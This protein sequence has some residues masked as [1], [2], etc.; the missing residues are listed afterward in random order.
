MALANRLTPLQQRR[1]ARVL[2]AVEGQ[3]EGNLTLTGLAS[4]AGCSRWQLQRAFAELDITLAYYVRQR[5]LCRA[6]W[7]LVYS[8]ERQ[9][10]IA[11]QCG[12]ESDIQFHRAFK[13]AFHTTPGRYRQRGSWQDCLLPLHLTDTALHWL[14]GN[15]GTM[16]STEL[17][18]GK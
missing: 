5:R 18:V 4:V 12:F 16:L 13:Q 2:E 14:D 15:T 9:A 17:V 3:L 6:A 1:V 10:D 11:R 8:C 7:L